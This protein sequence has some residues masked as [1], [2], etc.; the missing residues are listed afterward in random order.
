MSVYSTNFLKFSH[1]IFVIL[2]CYGNF[3]H[4]PTVNYHYSRAFVANENSSVFSIESGEKLSWELVFI[5]RMHFFSK[6]LKKLLK[7][8][9]FQTARMLVRLKLFC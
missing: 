3:S 8:S 1:F 9:K 6:N 4:L 7:K 5:S 2:Y